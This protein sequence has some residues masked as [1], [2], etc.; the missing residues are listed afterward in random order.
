[1]PARSQR[2]PRH[3]LVLVGGLSEGAATR[4]FWALG[5]SPGRERPVTARGNVNSAAV[6]AQRA[7]DQVD[8]DDDR[9]AIFRQ[10][11]YFPTPPWAARA[12]GEMLRRID[13]MATSIWEPACGEGHM[14]AA[15]AETFSVF[16]SDVYPHGYGQVLDFLGDAADVITADWIV[17]NP[18]FAVADPFIR[19]GL[20]RARRGVAML[21]R[22]QFLEGARRYPL[23]HGDDPLTLLSVF[24]ERVPMT[25]GRWDPKASSATG[26]AWFFWM[27]GAAPMPP[28]GIPPGTRDRLWRHDDAA[29]FGCRREAGLLDLMEATE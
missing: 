6:M 14:A 28:I 23:F 2:W 13:P 26:Y 21:L 1:M 15:L 9:T 7:P 12:G 22:L 4:L 25:L 11:D 29:R 10:L 19:L 17:S 27:K 24:A 8:G 3:V 16:A 20:R 18:P 5:G